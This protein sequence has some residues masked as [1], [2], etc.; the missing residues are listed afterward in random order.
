MKVSATTTQISS[1]AAVLRLIA[2]WACQ[3]RWRNTGSSSISRFAT[4][5]SSARSSR[6]TR[7]TIHVSRWFITLRK[8]P[9]AAR[10]NAG[11]SESCTICRTRTVLEVRWTSSPAKLVLAERIS[12]PGGYAV[13]APPDKPDGGSGRVETPKRRNQI[14][15]GADCARRGRPQEGEIVRR[16]VGRDERHAL[17]SQL[18]ASAGDDVGL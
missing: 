12:I 10:K 15:G 7:S 1:P 17:G 11:V 4:L 16:S 9:I 8:A 2:R 18:R 14:Q 3:R 5:D 6:W 13:I